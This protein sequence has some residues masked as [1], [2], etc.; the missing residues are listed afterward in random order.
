MEKLEGA[1][2]TISELTDEVLQLK[3]EKGKLER[4]NVFL[5]K[6]ITDIKKEQGRFMKELK[7]IG[8]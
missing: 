1:Y 4:K 3:E 8:F 7:K 2:R 6:K 5:D